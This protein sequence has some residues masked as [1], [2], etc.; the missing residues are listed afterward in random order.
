MYFKIDVN[1]T[2][3]DYIDY[4]I[5]ISVRSTY[6]KKNLR[7]LRIL[8]TMIFAMASLISF[9]QNGFEILGFITVTFLLVLFV[10]FQVFLHSFFTWNL[11]KQIK[12]L[13]KDGK[14]GYSPFSSFEFYDEKFIEETEHSKS[15]IK[16][17]KLERISVV[18]EKVV[19]LHVS[20]VGAY[21]IPVSSFGA[22]DTYN[23][24]MEFIKTKCQNIDIY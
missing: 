4:N 17:T 24:F 1:L 16:Y 14:M 23:R 8:L 18:D 6:G 10:L 12:L 20:N 13:K 9:F 19:Y 5:F 7:N 22:S 2:D 15:E 3:D 21:V 11:K